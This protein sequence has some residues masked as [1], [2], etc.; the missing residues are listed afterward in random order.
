MMYSSNHSMRKTYLHK[1][2]DH[3]KLARYRGRPES[4][5]RILFFSGGTALYALS[6]L[7]ISYT[8]NSIHLVTPF[9]DG[10]SSRRLRDAF[11]IIS[12]G[13]LRNRLMA[14]ADRSLSGTPPI[15]DLF[16][17]RFPLQADNHALILSLRDMVTGQDPLVTSIPEPMRAIICSHLDAFLLHMPSD[18]DLR[19]A[20]IGN[21]ILTGCYLNS[22]TD[23]D[24]VLDTY[25]RM[26]GVR[27]IVKPLLQEPLHLAAEL[28][29]GTLLAGQHLITGKEVPHISCPIQC[30]FLTES[31]DNPRPVTTHIGGETEDLIHRANL[32]CYPMGSFY[33]S[34]IANLIPSGVGKA[35]A[36]NRC[37]K[38]YVPN[39]FPD[40]EQTG[41][42][43]AQCV[44]IIINT[45]K[46][47]T[48]GIANEQLLNYVVLDT[49]NARYATSIDYERIRSL[50]IEIIDTSLVNT[51][52]APFIDAH[53]LIDVL[54]SL[55]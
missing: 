41:M 54:L 26:M 10:G 45:L 47:D 32:I 2:P 40:P 7:L 52:T 15:C 55:T 33:T 28:Q 9:D 30:I 49:Q 16:D 4:G 50:G 34:I 37:A 18:F 17:R 48:T 39:T 36:G 11:H 29:D 51:A 35:V 23:I 19:G 13:D 14:L 22:S 20:S 53:R 43:L 24:T 1:I 25:S 8:C 6:R 38:V 44:D 27:G 12:I 3:S 5:P 42:D 21:L 31:L 46:K